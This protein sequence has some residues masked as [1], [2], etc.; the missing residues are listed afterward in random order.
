MEREVVAGCCRNIRRLPQNI[1]ANG[2]HRLLQTQ[3]LP[4]ATKL[5]REG[6]QGP[7]MG[8]GSLNQLLSFIYLFLVVLFRFESNFPS[9]RIMNLPSKL[10][11]VNSCLQTTKWHKI[12]WKIQWFLTTIHLD[13]TFTIK[14]SSSWCFD[15][16]WC[17][18]ALALCNFIAPCPHAFLVCFISRMKKE[19]RKIRHSCQVRRKRVKPLQEL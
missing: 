17:F 4:T 16:L 10:N 19:K 7:A 12:P 2:C 15:N 11:G 5:W 13:V 3:T 18:F 9:L 1:A 8:F 6:G 14:Y